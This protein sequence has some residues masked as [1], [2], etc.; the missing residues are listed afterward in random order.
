MICSVCD[1]D[2]PKFCKGKC[3]RCYMRLYHRMYRKLKSGKLQKVSAD[4]AQ[5]KLRLREALLTGGE[6]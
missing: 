1:Q 6:S 4:L 3:Q 5:I 2:K